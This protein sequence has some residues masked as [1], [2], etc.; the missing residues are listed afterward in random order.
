MYI[1]KSIL[2]AV[3]LIDYADYPDQYVKI[4][5]VSRNHL[6]KF[7]L[8]RY[9]HNQ[10]DDEVAYHLSDILETFEAPNILYCNNRSEFATKL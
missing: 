2:D 1:V 5:L 8:L 4:I 6:T 7:V 3:D 10:R 9:L